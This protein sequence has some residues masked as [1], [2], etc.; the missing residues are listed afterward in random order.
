MNKIKYISVFS[1]LLLLN[2]CFMYKNF[3]C[4]LTNTCS[5]DDSFVMTP[6]EITEQ[7]KHNA[8]LEK[9]IAE[10]KKADDAAQKK[11]IA[12]I[13]EICS[14]YNKKGTANY[15]ICCSAREN[16]FE[17]IVYNYNGH[18]IGY[19]KAYDI[20][21]KNI[22]YYED[23]CEKYGLK[24]GTSEFYKCFNELEYAREMAKLESQQREVNRPIIINEEAPRHCSSQRIGDSVFTNCY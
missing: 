8:M 17:G 9:E 6:E 4:A 22:K 16:L 1:S 21:I 13:K 5:D 24:R 10:Q 3:E 14:H 2:G 11:A 7:E 23:R 18:N 12:K 15:A 19:A 20:M